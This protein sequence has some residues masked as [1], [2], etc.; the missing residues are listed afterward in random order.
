MK[1]TEG[2][3]DRYSW[4]EEQIAGHHP[5]VIKN[6]KREIG[7]L[8]KRN[9]NKLRKPKQD[10]KRGDC[11]ENLYQQLDN[12]CRHVVNTPSEHHSKDDHFL[13]QLANTSPRF[14]GTEKLVVD[15]EEHEFI[16]LEDVTCT[17]KQ[18]AIL[19]IKMGK[20][21]YD[22]LANEEKR[23]KESAKYLPQ[24]KLGFRLLG[25]RVHVNDQV[26]VRDK[27]WGK[28]FDENVYEGLT[29]FFKAGRED[30]QEILMSFLE[31]L[32]KIQKWFEQQRVF[33]FYASSLL[34]LYETDITLPHNIRIYMID[35]SHVFPAN[36]ELDENYLFG[37]NN[38]IRFVKEI[39]SRE[40]K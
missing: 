30:N 1:N 22:P 23:R 9:C 17:F 40:F 14:Y 34:F 20:V 32:Q 15:D 3:P 12:L 11:E 33:H 37:L 7:I 21:T 25:Y 35:F 27:E 6:G 2:L 5:S 36:G 26:Q 39:I 18:P 8:K 29:E 19:D 10:A 4:F 38:L 28:G 16:I 24:T 13:L 31:Q